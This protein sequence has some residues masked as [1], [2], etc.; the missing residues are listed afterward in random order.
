LKS[1]LKIF[2]FSYILSKT[3]HV[4][5]LETEHSLQIVSTENHLISL[6]NN[7]VDPL[8]TGMLLTSPKLQQQEIAKNNNR[9]IQ[10]GVTTTEISNSEFTI[11]LEDLLCRLEAEDKLFRCN[12]CDILF[13]ERGMYFLHKAL[14]N[15]NN[16]WQCSICHKIMQDK[17][18]FTLHFVNQK[19]LT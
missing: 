3:R 19:H 4:N 9:S 1:P 12:F 6:N 18:E 8:K 11:S 14:H 17:Y 7:D 5:Y 13:I 10:V 15:S 16:P 2:Y